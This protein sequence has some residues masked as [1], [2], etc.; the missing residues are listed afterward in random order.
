MTYPILAALESGLFDRVVVSSD[1]NEVGAIAA[2]EGAVYFKR[3]PKLGTNS[4]TAPM[5]NVVN[6][7]LTQYAA[8]GELYDY[9]CMLY[10]TA[11]FI[12][13]QRLQEG[14][15]HILDG[16]QFVF[17]MYKSPHPERSLYARGM[18]MTPRHPY[19]FQQPS[20]MYPESFH[21]AEGWWW[22]QSVA[23]ELYKGF[24]G[25]ANKGI[26]V[27]DVEAMV[28]D[29]EDDWRLAESRYRRGE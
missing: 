22:A 24:W 11:P 3:D 5:Y 9:V 4:D 28:I 12:T 8:L 16:H 2:R 21:P 25:D 17:P 7:V 26:L 15:K 23:L 14:Y 27:P 18:S 6:E 13:A 1:S 19:E 20:N 29:T 10:A